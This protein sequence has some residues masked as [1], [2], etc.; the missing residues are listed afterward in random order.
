MSANRELAKL[1][2]ALYFRA[3]AVHLREGYASGNRAMLLPAM[4]KLT[5]LADEIESPDAP[6]WLVDMAQAGMTRMQA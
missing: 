1:T 2:A 4:V 5:L 6:E 3:Q